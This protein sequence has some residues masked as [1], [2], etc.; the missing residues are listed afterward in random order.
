MKL[1]SITN[2]GLIET[3]VLVSFLVTLAMVYLM[4]TSLSQK[5]TEKTE[6]KELVYLKSKAIFFAD[7]LVKNSNEIEPEKG[8]AF[9][10]HEKKRVEENVIDLSLAEKLG[11]KNFPEKLKQVR[12]EFGEKKIIIGE[13]KAGCF[14][15]RRFV[16]VKQTGETGVV[17]VV[18]CN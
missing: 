7:S 5:I 18:V 14:E 16:L 11:E 17:F 1:K 3:D 8:I 2:K 6:E 10:N 13:K 12:I 9:F 15:A 4:L